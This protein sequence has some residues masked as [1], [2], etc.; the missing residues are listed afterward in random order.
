MQTYRKDTVQ[1]LQEHHRM[2]FL[3]YS[4]HYSFFILLMSKSWEKVTCNFT[5]SS[6]SKSKAKS[7]K[8]NLPFGLFFCIAEIKLRFKFWQC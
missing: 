1:S 5:H 6:E 3:F 7:R 2:G 8:T 4:A